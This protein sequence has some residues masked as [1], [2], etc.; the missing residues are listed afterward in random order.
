MNDNNNSVWKL[1][2]DLSSKK[3]ITE[4]VINNPKTVFVERGGQFIQLNVDLVKEDIYSFVDEVAKLNNG[5]CNID[6]PIL[7]GNLPDGSRINMIVEPY[8]HGCPAITI[9]KYLKHIKTFEES[10]DVFGLTPMWV[11]F[12]QACA[13][14]RMNVVISGGTG[15]G[16]TTFLNLMLNELSPAERVVTIED[17]LE[18][19]FDMANSV[20]LEGGGVKEK[21]GGLSTRDLVKN[22]LRMRPD[23]IIIGEI[24]GGELFD[25]LQAMNTGHE[26][27]MCSIHSNSPG[28]CLS[29]METLYLLAGYDV[30]FHVVRK[31]ISSA[32]DFI[33][34]ISRNREGKRVI[35]SIQ[36][37]TGM[38]SNS[39]L[40]QT[41]A[42]VEDD[43]LVH[44]G[45]TPKNM[46]RLSRH[47]GIPIDFFNN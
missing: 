5:V 16:K 25:L 26:G 9:R 2:N 37:I 4:I 32:V 20:R 39:I 24:R 11:K 7:D 1:I 27:S 45:I 23:R 44:T 15:V 30:P 17:T 19:S 10:P 28:E 31:Q 29:R 8:A 41:I 43:K 6:N 40:S 21:N 46:Q 12:L 3:G 18:L 22:T 34:Q 47:G 42:Q 36:E 33:V 38:E 14:S 35:T 13:S